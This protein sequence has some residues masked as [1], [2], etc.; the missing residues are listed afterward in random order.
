MSILDDK[1][2]ISEKSSG[3]S[4]RC[5]LCFYH[6]KPDGTDAGDCQIFGDVAKKYFGI[7]KKDILPK[8][9][10]GKQV[11]NYCPHWIPFDAE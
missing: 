7:R 9:V 6:D 2:F 11:G 5:G 10:G 4:R 1:P 3:I 8:L